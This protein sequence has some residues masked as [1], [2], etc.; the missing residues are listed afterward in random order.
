MEGP[1][2]VTFINPNITKTN[3]TGL[4]KGSYIFKVTVTDDNA[5]T[6]ADNVYVIVNQSEYL[7]HSI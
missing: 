7:N 5:N 3:V 1:T 6:A 2:A 4:T